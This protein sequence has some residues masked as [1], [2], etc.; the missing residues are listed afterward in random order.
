MKIK[1]KRRKD[2]WIL[3]FDTLIAKGLNQ[4]LSNV[5]FPICCLFYVHFRLSF[6][7]YCS[8]ERNTL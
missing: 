2:F 1:P 7:N 4:E 3:K 5:E 6:T 8:E